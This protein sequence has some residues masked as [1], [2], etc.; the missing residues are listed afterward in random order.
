MI[1]SYHK[2]VYDAYQKDIKEF[3]EHCKKIINKII[4]QELKGGKR[5]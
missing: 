3:E 4:K 2:I 5:T 1:K